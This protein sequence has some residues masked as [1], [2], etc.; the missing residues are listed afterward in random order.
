MLKIKFIFFCW[1]ICVIYPWLVLGDKPVIN[2]VKV[3]FP[4]GYIID[5]KQKGKGYGDL[6]DQYM[7]KHLD[8]YDHEISNQGNWP[9]AF[10][11]IITGNPMMCMSLSFYVPP[12][13]RESFLGKR[14]ISAPNFIFFWHDVVAR[15][16][17]QHL[18]EKEVSFRKLLRNQNLIFGYARTTGPKY[19]QILAEY[20]GLSETID[21][22][23]QALSLELMEAKSNIHVRTS[24]DVVGGLLKMLVRGRVDY[25]LEYA[26]MIEYEAIRL[27]IRDQ[28]I[29]LPVTETRDDVPWSAYS[30]SDTPEGREATQA[31]NRVLASARDTKEYKQALTYLIPKGREKEY[32][33][34]YEKILTVME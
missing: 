11:S 15:K 21:A 33:K 18:F 13:E 17:K 19:N 10:R 30:C 32:W 3:D 26:F 25:I 16:D 2:W 4:P 24:E 22:V 12:E 31:I 20:I 8:Q 14:T 27:G 29:S 7:I 28:L 1:L 9:R 23:D 5:G 34:H 6:L